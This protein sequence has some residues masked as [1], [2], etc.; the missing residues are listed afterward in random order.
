LKNLRFNLTPLAQGIALA[1]GVASFAVPVMAESNTIEEVVV[2]GIRGSLMDAMN[3]KRDAQGVVDAISAEDIGKFPDTNL[4]ESLQR[5]SG[6][7]IDRDIG[8]GSRITVRGVGPDF[9]LVTLNGR[10]MPASSIEDTTVSNSRAFDFANLASESIRAVEVYKTSRASLPTGGIGATVNILTARPLDTADMVASIGVKAVMD[11][12]TE[13]GSTATPELSGI[14]SNTYADGTF[15]VAISAS[16]Q[17]R[18]LGFNQASV[19]NGWRPFA[20]DQQ[21]DWGNIPL[22][23]DPGSENITNRPDATDIYSVPQNLGYSFNE[24]QRTRTNGMLTLQWM[25]SDAITTTLDYTYSENEIATQRS[26]LSA[27]FNYGPST[28]SWTDGPVAGP[29]IY[30]EAIPAANSDIAMGGADF[31]TRNENNSIG[32][33]VEWHATDDLSLTFDYHNSDAESGPDSPFGSNAVLGAAA[34]VR[35]DTTANF[36][37]EFPVLSI[38]LPAGQTGLD[39]SQM[40]VTGSAFRNSFM[41]SEIEQLQLTGDYAF[42]EVSSLDFGFVMTDVNNRSAFQ[43]VQRDSW[44]GTGTP[45]DYDDSVFILDSVADKFD[46]FGESSDPALFNQYFKWDFGAVRNM[47]I[48]AIGGDATPY[49]ASS[50]YDT[51]RRT[52]EESMSA[53]VQ[54]NRDFEMGAMPAAFSVG[55]RYE[56][57][58]VSSSAKVPL[59]TGLEWAAANEFS[60][61]FGTA[62]FTELGGKYDYILPSFDVSVDVADDMVVRFGYSETIGR[63]GWGD[64]QGGQTINQLVRIDGGTGAQGDPGLKPLESQ[65]FDVSYEWY[66]GDASYVAISYFRKSIDNYVGVS[67]IVDTPF[68]LPH[69][70]QG[71]RFDEANA[72]TGGTGDLV[73]IRNYIF[74]NFADTP[75]VTVTGVDVNGNATGTIAGIAGQDPATD[76]R[77]TVPSNQREAT[78]DGW[79]FAIQHMFGASGFGAS[80][81]MTIVDSDLAYN[82]ADRGDQFA[83]EGLSDSA[84]LIGFYEKD[85]WQARL[86]YNWRDT[87]L[88]GRFDGS[89]LP[90]PVYTEE[91]GQ[92]DFNVSYMFNDDLTVFVEGINLTDETQRLHGRNENQALFVTQTGPRYMVGA[93]YNL[94]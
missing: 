81:N 14:F 40:L 53:F 65:N 87:F 84:N 28:S 13:E 23:G 70:G 10:Q 89:G 7:S 4:A 83:L 19:G 52:S 66:Y 41:K 56:E 22:A 37:G 2:T 63:P 79:E 51:D 16:Y 43:N 30:S 78:L 15:G 17:D 44:G 42:D 91:Y 1:L 11:T 58:D 57:T 33:N 80:A 90:N 18:D 25:P 77:I 3:T 20:G 93:R 76:F 31:A 61:Q 39:P 26:E 72:A 46:Q 29:I 62:G 86:A 48:A 35:G 36:G 88:S 24:L 55:L 9:N 67:T 60:V 59:A 38:A 21:G 73:L 85:K 47:A 27:W 69:P 8:E 82:N 71:A 50:N 6:V 94:K 49:T 68:N 34:F 74:A 64:I 5:I 75:E 32:L 45:A 92:I 54:Y 12:S